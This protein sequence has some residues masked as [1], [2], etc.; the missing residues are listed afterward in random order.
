[1]KLP[2][3]ISMPRSRSTVLFENMAP[4]MN[5]IG[6]PHI[7]NHA[8]YFLEWGRNVEFHDIKTNEKNMTE[9]FPVSTKN[10]LGLH[11]I[12][13]P[14]FDNGYDRCMHKL[15]VLQ[16]EKDM[17][18]EYFIKG[19]LNISRATEEVVDFFSDKKFIL[20]KRRSVEDMILSFMFAWEC[21]IFHARENNVEIY[22]ELLK[23]PVEGS[24]ETLYGYVEFLRRAETV[25]AY[26]KKQGYEYQVVDYE[27]LDTDEKIYSTID[28]IFETTEWR[29]HMP[30]T[31]HLP[32]RFDKDYSNIF[33]N[34][35]ELKRIINEE[36][37]K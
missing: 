28:D 11:F 22:K 31:A 2:F 34:I 5:H 35:T 37:P 12:Y 4:Y 13:P 14:V 3:L 7:K 16:Q 32:I 8:E 23:T 19:T 26:I 6:H 18:R 24:I 21:K 20:T 36:F 15:A 29:N 9:L 10:E 30:Q 17:G 25:E 33:T 1:M 27:D